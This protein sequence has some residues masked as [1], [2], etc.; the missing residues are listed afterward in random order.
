MEDRYV[1]NFTNSNTRAKI[2]SVK[3]LIKNLGEILISFLGGV[4]LEFY[5]TSQA[6]LII[7]VVG[8]VIVFWVLAFMKKRIGLRPEEYEEEDI[9]YT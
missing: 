4:L 7:G 5:P 3:N 6:Y 9:E 1:T 2:L 8:L